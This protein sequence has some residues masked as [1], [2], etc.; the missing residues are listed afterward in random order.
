MLKNSPSSN[1][2]P[3]E[4]SDGIKIKFQN[5]LEKKIVKVNH[6]DKQTTTSLDVKTTCPSVKVNCYGKEI[7]ALI[8]CAAVLN[9]ITWNEFNCL[10]NKKNKIPLI[11]CIQKL[12]Q[13]T[14]HDNSVQCNQQAMIDII[15]GGANIPVPFF[16]VKDAKHCMILGSPFLQQTGMNV[17]YNN[18]T[19]TL[20]RGVETK[21]IIPMEKLYKGTDYDLML[22]IG[23]CTPNKGKRSK[24]LKKLTGQD[25]IDHKESMKIKHKVDSSPPEHKDDLIHLIDYVTNTNEFDWM[26]DPKDFLMEEKHVRKQI[27]KDCPIINV[28]CYGLKLQS[29]IDSGA[30]VN[31]I[32]TSLFESISR[33]ADIPIRTRQ[34]NISLAIEHHDAVTTDMVDLELEINDENFFG[35]FVIIKNLRQSMIL[36]C[37]FLSRYKAL[38][39][40]END[41][42]TLRSGEKGIKI[43]TTMEGREKHINALQ[44]QSDFECEMDKKI[45]SQVES[46]SNLNTEQKDQIST[47]L[48]KHKNVFSLKPGVIQ[49]NPHR[50]KLTSLDPIKPKLYPVA[51]KHREA[52]D[53]Q[54]DN[55]VKWG[56]IKPSPT[57]YLSP[58]VVVKKP[59]D[60]IRICIDARKL[61]EVTEPELDAPPK[62]EDLLHQFK[63]K[64]FF[65]STDLTSSFW[66][67]PIHEDDQKFVGFKHRNLTYVWCRTP[68]GLRNSGASLI[69]AVEEIFKDDFKRGIM[70]Y[71]DDI[72]CAAE[73]FQEHLEQ[74]EYV[75]SKLEKA[76]F[77][78]KLSKSKFG[79][80]DIQFLGHI[81]SQDGIRPDNNKMQAIRE[82]PV[83]RNLKQLR[84]FLGLC[85]YYNKFCENYAES[86]EPLL[87]L[88]RGK[89][90]W[91]WEPH[92]QAAFEKV[93]EKFLTS[94]MISHPD[95]RNQMI[96]QTDASD[97]A[98]SACLFQEDTEGNKY[99]LAFISRILKGPERHYCTTEKEGLAIIW[100][101]QRLR[102]MILGSKLV[103][104]TDHKALTFLKQC[105]LTSGRITRWIILL[106]EFDYSIEHVSGKKN[107]IPDVL[108]RNYYDMPE[109][110][111]VIAV[112]PDINIRPILQNLPT[113]QEMDRWLGPVRAHL[114]GVVI[115]NMKLR[116]RILRF[117]MNFKMK[118]NLLW[119]NV[120]GKWRVCVPTDIREKLV[121]YTHQE[122][123]HVG[124]RKVFLILREVFT[125]VNMRKSIH[126]LLNYCD[127]CQRNKYL[128]C[129]YKG[130]YK[131]IIP[132]APNE[133]LSV[134]IY[135]P[136][137]KGKYGN[138][139][140]FVCMDVFTKFT[141][142]YPI[143]KANTKNCVRM[144][145]RHYIPLCGVPTT[146]LSDHGK[147]FV[148][149]LW[150]QEME[151]L[152]ITPKLS[153][154]RHPQ[155]NPVERRMREI[156][157]VIRH[158][159]DDRHEK[160]F[161]IIPH[162][163]RSFNEV[164]HESTL[165][166]PQEAHFG[167]KVI[168]P[169]SDLF[170][171][172][173]VPIAHDQLIEVIHRRLQS[174]GR[175]RRKYTT[176]KHFNFEVGTRVLLR[177]PMPSD[178]FQKMYK[179]FYP[180]Y[181]EPLEI[182]E[183]LGNNAYR[184]AGVGGRPVGVFN[185][186][187][188]RPFFSKGERENI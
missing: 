150:N 128:N 115:Q 163:N 156:N 144:I 61:N 131:P 69:R 68:F 79:R 166:T 55:M 83:P 51:E 158:Y 179:K 4:N 160:W 43:P 80:T 54:V 53:K 33:T 168:R 89:V 174:A 2:N 148:S 124:P 24:D 155:S 122:Y 145:E 186:A 22:S 159:S 78:I 161:E 175:R 182:V 62:I 23:T 93:K 102:T 181:S 9:F 172:E 101:L 111:N 86:T 187:N 15:I 92:H 37:P 28:K 134:D 96:L 137:P 1:L 50:I 127:S 59:D 19:L 136:I 38:L 6:G 126:D 20:N 70:I 120:E 112:T 165:I 180:L 157:R 132:S 185:A 106:N 49:G 141:Q 26:E 32:S 139:F 87:T 16:I 81:I 164:H 17:D 74:L 171:L 40:Y 82:Y 184:L 153:T 91:K 5:S 14:L 154:I 18:Q 173:D 151:R 29:L 67:V 76:G 147:S 57:S 118:D 98:I 7:V 129:S 8:D 149:N 130:F 10:N 99:V 177:T 13:S 188:I 109:Q 178:S 66:H 36:G 121:M 63:G 167:T 176:R 65:S 183:D 56:I 60:T 3:K 95:F 142:V 135:G 123:Y 46:T 94:V 77:T 113:A 52:V 47:I 97:N 64:K 75:F 143:N 39:D 88:L 110:L 42:I 116:N 152:G 41:C 108:S 84:G 90:K 169:F 170:V 103:I 44:V 85:N 11:P 58:L 30:N 25:L 45:K 72:L 140:L 138:K 105:S 100:S 107:M 27:R 71:V 48:Q 114:C 12:V 31:T 35:S 125:W 117:E 133:L 162:L 146:I 73:T 119:K 104:R 21:L 34:G